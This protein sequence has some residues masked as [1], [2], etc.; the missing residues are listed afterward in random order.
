MK[1]KRNY[2]SGKSRFLTLISFFIILFLSNISAKKT[3]NVFDI[4][5]EVQVINDVSPNQAKK[6]ALNEAKIKALREAGI[7]ESVSSQELLFKSEINNDFTDFF[8]SSS[9]IEIKGAVQSYEVASE[10][11]YCKAQT[12][13]IYY[14][15]TINAKVV[16]YSSSADPAFDAKVEGVNPI[17]LQNTNLKFSLRSTLDCHLLIFSIGDKETSLLFPSSYEESFKI[18]ALEEYKFPISQINYTMFLD[19][20][21]METN[22]L[23]FLFTKEKLNYINVNKEGLTNKEDLFSFIYSI[24]PDVRKIEYLTYVITKRE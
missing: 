8:S 14:S 13:D 7:S 16:K 1:N 3:I 12:G 19:S 20:G 4:T 17:Y 9:Q 22:R 11:L 10:K 2:L 6:I 18:K 15:I 24:P 21:K 5:T 23:V